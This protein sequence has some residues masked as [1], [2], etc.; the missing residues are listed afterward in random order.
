MKPCLTRNRHHIDHG[1][2]SVMTT[3][4]R[5][6]GGRVC[7]GARGARRVGGARARRY[8]DRLERQRVNGDRGHRGAAAA[9]RGVELRDGSGRGV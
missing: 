4:W 2:V 9:G 6:S 8:G 3:L 1:A 5:S 7:R